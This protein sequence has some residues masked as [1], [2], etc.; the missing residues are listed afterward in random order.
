MGKN[1]EEKSLEEA[2]VTRKQ[3]EGA[4]V[5]FWDRLFHA[6]T[7]SGNREGPITDGGG[8]VSDSEE[9]ERRRLQAGWVF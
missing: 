2:E 8:T 9:A 3:T 4:D 7:G 6:D 1:P 5:T